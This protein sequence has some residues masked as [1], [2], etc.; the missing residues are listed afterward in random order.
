MESKNL[1]ELRER[2][3]KSKESNKLKK[4]QSCPS[5]RSINLKYTGTTGAPGY[6][7]TWN[8]NNCGINLVEMGSDLYPLNQLDC[9]QRFLNRGI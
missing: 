9:D 7:K 3:A 1:K 5:C 8:C 6:G 4:D 2:I